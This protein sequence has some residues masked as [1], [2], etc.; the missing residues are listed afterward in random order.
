MSSET[1]QRADCGSTDSGIV[2]DPDYWYS[3]GSI[4]I[5]VQGVGFRV[6][7]S[8]LA[9]Q[10]NAFRDLFMVPTPPTPSPA[11]VMDGC[12][13]V[14]LTDTSHDFRELL[15]VIYSGPMSVH[16]PRSSDF[17]A[18]SKRADDPCAVP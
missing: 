7:K 13:V 11:D 17:F 18:P 5:V 6:H 14:R 4:V 1:G 8:L 12:P 2:R 9:Q 15:R 3:D 10:S 16:E